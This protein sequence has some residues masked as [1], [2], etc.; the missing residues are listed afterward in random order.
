M[1]DTTLKGNPVRAVPGRTRR[2]QEGRICS[3]SE[4][5][6]RLSVYNSGK[7]C[8]VHTPFKAPIMR[9]KKTPPRDLEELQTVG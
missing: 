8:A 2:Y 7:T 9:G 5:N 6:T 1:I 4:C 3:S